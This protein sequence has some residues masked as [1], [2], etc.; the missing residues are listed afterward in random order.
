M[1]PLLKI[2]LTFRAKEDIKFPYYAGSSL[3]GLF[4]KSLRKVSCLSPKL[5]CQECGMAPNC[6]YASVFENGYISQHTP[7]RIPNP[8]IIEPMPQGQKEIKKDSTFSFEQILFGTSVNKLSYILLSWTK[9]GL[10]GFTKT[11][12]QATLI[13]IEQVLPNNDIILLHDL[14]DPKA[15]NFPPQPE[16]PFPPQKNCQKLQITLQTPLRIH[17]DGHPITPDALTAEFFLTSLIRKQSNMA[18]YHIPTFP[19]MDKKQIHTS[20][21]SIQMTEKSLHWLDWKRYSS[22]QKSEI[23]LGGIIGTFCL[24]GDLTLLYPYIILGQYFHCGKSTVMGLGKY[25]VIEHCE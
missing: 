12:T 1:F 20:I 3:R 2:R 21:K 14:E 25:Q 9:S 24:E 19:P 4:G 13:K 10:Q 22:R 18:Q 17:H 5:N 11:R 16:F 6:P 15:I 23:A 8:Y 7:D